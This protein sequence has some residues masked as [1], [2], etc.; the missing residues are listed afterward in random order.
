MYKVVV[1][2]FGGVD[3]LEIVERDTPAPTSEQVRVRLTSI[4]MNHA[5]LM[6]RRGQYK[7]S[8]G[9]PPFTPGLEGGGIVDAIG[10][11]VTRLRIGDRV[12]LG[13]DAPQ[14]ARGGEGTYQSHYL[15]TADRLVAAPDAL[16]DEQL[17][18]IWLAYLTAWGCLC[19]KQAVQP[20]Q[21]VLLPAASSSVALAA[22]QLLADIGCTTIGTTTSPDKVDRLGAMAAARYDHL[23][24]T[25]DRPWWTDVKAITDGRGCDVIFDPVAAGEFLD[26]EIRLL[27][28]GGALWIYGLLGASGTVDVTP[29]I[30]RH[31]SIRGWLLGEL[32][33]AGGEALQTGYAYVLDRLADGRF[34]LPVAKTYPLRD[35]RRAHEEMELGRHLGKLI[36]LPD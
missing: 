21:V 11:G 32:T 26:R 31:A 18:A 23:V 25:H 7:L 1:R 19:W 3:Q 12:I 35:V 13:I 8:T 10:D 16:A 30:R 22:S 2:A 5:E 34:V 27:A 17:G 28:K 4:G 24:L 20:G 36:L 9:D 33:E 15:V 6:G 14:R 29:L